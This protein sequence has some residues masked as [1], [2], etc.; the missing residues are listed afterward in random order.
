MDSLTQSITELNS[1][2]GALMVELRKA[3]AR[4]RQLE[5]LNGATEAP[6]EAPLRG[7]TT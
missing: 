2:V 6:R 1:S 5:Q 4:I 7:P 3:E